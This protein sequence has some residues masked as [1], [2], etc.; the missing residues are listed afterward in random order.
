MNIKDSI[1]LRIKTERERQQMSREVLCLDG[2]ELTVRQLIRIEKGESLPSLDKLSYIAKRLGK[3][4]SDLLDHDN[5]TIPNEYYEMKNRLIK[6]PT[7]R[8]PERIKSKLALIEEVYEKF[9][10]LLPEEE[11]L[12]LDILEN[13]LSFTNWEESPKVEEIYED[14]FEQVKRKKK[15]STNDLLVIDYYFFHLYGRKQFDKKL[16]ERIVKRVLNQEIWTDDVYNIVLFN[17]LMAIA[18]LKIFH[19]S[20]SDFLTVV[21]KAI[22][23]IEKSQFYSYKPS[24]F[25]LKAKYELLHKGNKK[26]AAENYD[27]AIMFASVLEDSVLEESIRAGKAADGL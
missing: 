23:V 12:T 16:F 10:E 5:I 4:M 26:K 18:A 7:Y 17:D 19:N 2:A 27:K 8:N 13:I 21:D 11:L 14:L 3:N 1:G 20:F 22:A 24:V 9:F 25:V 6:F 15:F